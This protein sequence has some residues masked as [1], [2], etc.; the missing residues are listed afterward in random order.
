MSK[1]KLQVIAYS[2]LKSLQHDVGIEIGNAESESE[3]KIFG[4]SEELK[5]YPHIIAYDKEAD[6][7][8]SVRG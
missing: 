5:D 2:S 8:I 1:N 6:N 4:E 7:T 3:L